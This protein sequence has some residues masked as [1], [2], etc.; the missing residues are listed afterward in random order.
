MFENETAIDLNRTG[1]PLLEIVS[2][3][4]LRSAKDAATY[5]RTIQELVKYLKICDGDLSRGSMRCDANV[6]IR[7]SEATELGERQK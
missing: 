7:K 6:S 5:F 2:E 3:P 4:D 1:T